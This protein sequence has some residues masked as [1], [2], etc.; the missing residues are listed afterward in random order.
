MSD[1]LLPYYEEELEYFRRVAPEFARRHPRI[2]GRL[3]MSSA[4]I[5]DP[6]VER[7]IQAVAFLNARTRR[8]ID[9]DFPEISQALLQV[10]YPQYLAPFPSATIVRFALADDQA[11]L[12]QGFPIRRLS[13]LETDPVDGEPYRFRT[14]Y[15][16]TL[17]PVE[18]VKAGISRASVELPA[19]SWTDQVRARIR[20]ELG[21][22][23][24]KLP[25]AAMGFEHLRFFINAPPQIAYPLYE[26]IFNDTVGIV[27]S[28]GDETRAGRPLDRTCLGFVGF[29]PDEAL[30]E[31]L[32]RSFPA[33]ELLTEFFVFPQKFLFFELR[34]LRDTLR[35]YSDARSLAIDLCLRRPLDSLERNVNTATFQL[36]CTPVVN[37]FRQP[38]ESIELTHRKTEYRVVPD[39][40]RPRAYEI[41]SIDEVTGVSPTKEKLP[42]AP[43]YSLTHHRTGDRQVTRFWHATRRAEETDAPDRTEMFVSIVDSQFS[44]AA[45]N[46]WTLDV[47]TTCLNPRRLPFGGGQP[48]FRLDTGGPLLPVECLT[49][50]TKACRPPREST[51]LWQLISHLTL[52]HLSLVSPDGSPD[53]LREILRLYDMAESS[54]SQNLIAGL[55]SVRAHRTSGRPGGL[56]SAGVCRG[57]EVTLHFDEDKFS[58]SGLYLFGAVLERFLGM[59]TALNSFTRTVITTNRRDGK[60]CEWPA[61]AGDMVFL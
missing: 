61:R 26:A 42:Y 55:L 29:N 60:L 12:T 58:G 31:P 35:R 41:H 32:A 52:N 2:A 15:P 45:Q 40:R 47:V 21:S 25:L 4:D 6:H 14:C 11:E 20:I 5:D 44:P 34:G 56:V 16:V 17:W 33:Y 48:G 8:K 7:L 37:L 18:I 24:R 28:S 51:T 50:P 53:P 23:G 59:Y 30:V 46:D 39:A 43:F 3:R 1:E 10:L 19:T 57:L 22:Y 38:A 54:E 49:A 13:T 36:G 9:D 27:V